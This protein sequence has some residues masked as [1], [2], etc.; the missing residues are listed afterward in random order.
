MVNILARLEIIQSGGGS[1]FT[2]GY[3]AKV[4]QTQ[5]FADTGLVNHKTGNTASC[6]LVADR[7]LNH[8]LDA[9]EA[10]AKNDTWPRAPP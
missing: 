9:I 2:V 7:E 5:C 3:G 1:S 4:T 8:F 6:E 10:I